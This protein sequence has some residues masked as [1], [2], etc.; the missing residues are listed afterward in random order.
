MCQAKQQDG[1]FILSL[2]YEASSLVLQ[3]TILKFVLYTKPAC[4]AWLVKHNFT[5]V[6]IAGDKDICSIING[7]V[8]VAMFAGDAPPGQRNGT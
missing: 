1:F 2:R 4:T 3:G 6:V 7:Q 8:D 5:M